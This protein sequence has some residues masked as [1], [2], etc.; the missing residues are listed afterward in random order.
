MG[1]LAEVVYLRETH[2]GLNSL[3][4]YAG[5]PGEPPPGSKRAKVLDWLRRVNLDK[6]VE[7]LDVLGKILENYLEE[8]DPQSQYLTSKEY[9]R[10]LDKLKDSLARANL[11]YV[12]GGLVTVALGSPSTSLEHLIRDRQLGPVNEEF[13][14]AIER[15]K[16]NAREAVSAAC[17][18]LEAV[19][20]VYIYDEGLIMP[21]KKD[22]IPVWNV[23]RRHLGWD[24]SKMSDRDVQEILS[25]LSAVVGGIGALRTHASSAHGQGRG[26]YRIE[27]RHARLA[28]HAAHTIVHFIIET[29]DK[30][31]SRQATEGGA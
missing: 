10:L 12:K 28:I 13:Y 9:P 16:E 15:V 2:D 29:W 4:A 5:A 8:D 20:K 7:P 26:S 25:G 3:F 11:K 30:Q 31:K 23:V 14:R 6:N 21:A 27:D 19:C 18:I 24:Q 17:N 22:L 1:A